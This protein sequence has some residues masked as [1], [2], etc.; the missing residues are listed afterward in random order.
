VG[1]DW[2]ADIVGA[3]AAG[4]R[5]AWLTERPPDTPLPTSERDESVRPDLELTGL[6]ELE[7]RLGPT[8]S[9]V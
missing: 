9:S 4:W 2:A 8:R 6:G 1:D 5:T 7:S 3:S